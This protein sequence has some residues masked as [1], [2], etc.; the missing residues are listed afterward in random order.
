VDWLHRCKLPL[1]VQDRGFRRPRG[2]ILAGSFTDTD[3]GSTAIPHDAADIDDVEAD[4]P[5]DHEQVRDG[6]DGEAGSLLGVTGI[7]GVRLPSFLTDIGAVVAELH[8]FTSW[9]VL[10]SLP[11]IDRLASASIETSAI[12][13]AWF[14]AG[15]GEVAKGG[16]GEHADHDQQ[17]E[18]QQGK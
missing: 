16:I 2:S 3:H 11:W 15:R 7:V 4:Q 12:S 1:Q 17:A 5:S 10:I 18:R 8:G 6:T 13:D 9:G 14:T